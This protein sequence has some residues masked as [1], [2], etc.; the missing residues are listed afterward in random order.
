MTV[1]LLLQFLSSTFGLLAHLT[2]LGFSLFAWRREIG[3]RALIICALLS[4][5]FIV[6]ASTPSAPRTTQLAEF[7][8]LAAWSGFLFRATGL[9]AADRHD[10]QRRWLYLVAV[11]VVLATALGLASVLLLPSTYLLSGAIIPEFAVAKVLLCVFGLVIIEQLLRNTRADLHSRMRYLNI[12]LGLIFS[13]GVFDV[14]LE[15]LTQQRAHLLD[16]VYPAVLGLAVPFVLIATL[17]NRANPL[18]VNLSREFVFRSGVLI[19][20][21]VALMAAATVAYYVELDDQDSGLALLLVLAITILVTAF[22]VAG[23][24]RFQAHARRFLSRHIY[25]DQ[26]DYRTH[27]ARVTDQLTLSDPDFTLEQQGIRALLSI[28]DAPAGAYW[29]YSD[30]SFFLESRLHCSWSSPLGREVSAGLFEVLGSESVVD[31]RQPLADQRLQPLR[32]EPDLCFLVPLLTYERLVGVIGISG[33]LAPIQLTDEDREI[34]RLTAREIAGFLALKETDRQF[35]E[36]RQFQALHQLTAFLVHDV[37]T[38]AAQL[39]MLLE[40]APVH[41]T[42]PLFIDDMID[43]V[44]NATRRLESLLEQLRG[45]EVAAGTDHVTLSELLPTLVERFRN[46][47]PRPQLAPYDPDASI[48]AD[49]DK[50]S[51]ALEHLLQNAVDATDDGGSILLGAQ[52][53]GAWLEL[54]IEDTGAGMAPD[55]VERQ[56]FRPF[57][58]TKGVQGMGIGA[59]QVRETVRAFG[60]DVRVDSKPGRGTKVI[61]RLPRSDHE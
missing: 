60:G 27:W 44:D 21:G 52:A 32:G 19:S 35:G 47:K 11:G 23:S 16:I 25:S 29:R 45:N 8:M 61:I 31:L 46:D 40:N 15:V 12:G 26:H 17:R 30:G 28:F 18:R 13:Y 34:I 57:D 50:L 58:S 7:L 51:A 54:V 37:K 55:F 20:V 49:R 14:L 4:V 10:T 3:G 38:T 53:S 5:A 24:T 42:N 43:T 6:S 39:A 48:C 33:S 36:A 1:L 56:L 41:K 59:Y 9:T 22:V 2:L